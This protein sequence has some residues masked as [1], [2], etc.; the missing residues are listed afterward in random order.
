MN[1]PT[2]D[3]PKFG[4]IEL[5][6]N[7]ISQIPRSLN[8]PDNHFNNFLFNWTIF[9]YSVKEK[10]TRKKRAEFKNNSQRNFGEYFQNYFCFALSLF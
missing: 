5:T 2:V 3:M 1:I 6:Q 9:R 8:N 4:S 7:K 10:L